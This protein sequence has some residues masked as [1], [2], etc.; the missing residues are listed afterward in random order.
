MLSR[1]QPLGIR[2]SRD[3]VLRFHNCSNGEEGVMGILMINCPSTGRAVSTG[4]EMSGVEQLPTVIATTDCSECGRVHEW[5]KDDAW[6]AEGGEQYRRIGA[7]KSAVKSANG[8][9]K[10]AV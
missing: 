2:H 3:M 7:D 6:L 8:H 10:G 5:T 4:I 1:G 9:L